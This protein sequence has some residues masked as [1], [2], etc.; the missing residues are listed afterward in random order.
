VALTRRARMMATIKINITF[1]MDNGTAVPVRRDALAMARK[2]LAQ[3]GHAVGNPNGAAAL[4]KAGKGNTAP[5]LAAVAT[6]NWTTP[7]PR[8]QS[9]NRST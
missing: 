6:G 3:L 4:G 7:A 5:V 9:S 8:H 1:K 2:R